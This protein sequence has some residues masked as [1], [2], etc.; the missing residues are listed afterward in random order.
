MTIQTERRAT[1]GVAVL[2]RNGSAMKELFD[3][4]GVAHRL[5]LLQDDVSALPMFHPPLVLDTSAMSVMELART[6][7]QLTRAS[8]G[9]PTIAIVRPRAFSHLRLLASCPAISVILAFPVDAVTLVSVLRYVRTFGSNDTANGIVW[10]EV[11]PLAFDRRVGVTDLLVALD[12]A[13]SLYAVQERMYISRATLRRRLVAI[14]AMLGITATYHQPNEWQQA[15][16]VALGTSP[17][18]G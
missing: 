9:S 11:P 8:T 10:F 16:L 14:A 5:L 15:I 17:L 13:T 2:T 1:P 12:G 7:H 4:V 6:L 18:I 3:N